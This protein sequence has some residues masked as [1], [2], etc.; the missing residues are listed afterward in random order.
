MARRLVITPPRRAII[1]SQDPTESSTAIST[2]E[3]AAGEHLAAPPPRRRLHPW[4]WVAALLLHLAVIAFVLLFGWPRQPQEEQSPPGVAVVFDKG[5]TPQTVAPPA[6]RQGPPQPAQA[7]MPAAPPP[8]SPQS[9]AEV[10]LNMPPMPLGSVQSAPQA[11]PQPRQVTH[12]RPAPPQKYVV[13]N[14]MSYSGHPS[15]PMPRA[16]SAMNLDL[17]QS[18]AQAVNAP[19]LTI[20]GEIGADWR[21]ALD[22]WVNQHKYYPQAALEQDQQGSVEIEFTV[23]RAGNVTGL[24]LLRGSGSPFLDQ[25]WQGLFAQNQLPPFPTGTK[26]NHVT[27]DATMHFELIQ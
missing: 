13:M 21:A 19:E 3:L 6:P 15:P 24:H 12:P 16:K 8:P 7:A 26:S 2:I 9:Q 10:N 14:N 4:A 20:K 17:A 27:V 1:T 5:G 18:D 23:D 25:A 11:Q 22:K